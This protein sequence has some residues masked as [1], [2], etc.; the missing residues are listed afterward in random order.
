MK[1]ATPWSPRKREQTAA[2]EAAKAK[3]DAFR[4]EVEKSDFATAAEGRPRRED[5]DPHL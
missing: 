2:M 4:S 5:E 1:R 3:A